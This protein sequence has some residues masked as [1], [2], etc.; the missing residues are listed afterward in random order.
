M[1]AGESF[2]SVEKTVL[3]CVLGCECVVFA[4][5]TEAIPRNSCPVRGRG[6]LWRFGPRRCCSTS[7]AAPL[8]GSPTA[9]TP[10][11]QDWH[12][13]FGVYCTSILTP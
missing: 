10:P 2:L 5:A 6:G 8:G 9:K 1:T 7:V 3:V 13:C 12:R 4:R 11:L